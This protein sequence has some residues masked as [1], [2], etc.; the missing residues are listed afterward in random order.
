[1]T[2]RRKTREVWV[3]SVGIGGSHPV[4]I[5]SMTT[6]PTREVQATVEQ[7]LR[8]E[9]AGCELVR[10]TVQGMKEAESCEEIKTQLLQKNCSLPLIADIHFY[11]P[12]A[13]KVVDFVDKVRINPGNFLDKR[14]LFLKR[15]YDDSSYQEEL[16]RIKEG[17]LPFLDKCKRLGKPIRIGANHGSL[18]DRIMNRYGD[19][20]SGM[21]ESALEFAR[22]CREQEFHHLIFS[23]KASNPQVMIE[24][25]L[26]LV[27]HM[28]AL[29]WDYPLHLGVTEA[30]EGEDGRIKS[31]IGIGSLLLQGLGD[32][33][34]VSLTEDPWCEIEPAKLLVSYAKP[35]ATAPPLLQKAPEKKAMLIVEGEGYQP[36]TPAPDFLWIEKDQAQDGVQVDIPILS[37]TL[38]HPGVIPM[39]RLDSSTKE[40]REAGS[41]IWVSGEDRS[42][43]PY[44]ASLHPR[45]FLFSPSTCLYAEAKEFLYAL[46]QAGSSCEIVL[47]FSAK[48]LSSE[49][50]IMC[51]GIQYGSLLLEGLFSGICIRHTRASEA[52]RM[53][54]ALLQASRRRIVKTEFV[55]C[56]GCGRTLF[57]LQQVSRNIRERTSHL[58]GV[59]IAIMG[60][61]VNGPGEMADADFGYVG[62]RSGKIDLYVGK[63]CV[64]KNIDAELAVDR[65]IFLIKSQGKWIDST[66]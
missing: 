64:E 54:F 52:T 24:A 66:L 47:V 7:I 16:M 14:A 46:Q 11:P 53:G 17:F 58:P 15:E 20:P 33:L 35:V 23:M 25:Y 5:Q 61:I 51:L 40:Q 2:E 56:P 38:S 42:L 65:L 60:C 49:E 12:A 55:S 29:G 43:F 28:D 1:M 3:G 36:Q 37:A 30:G 6:S 9:Q 22:I 21:V 41:V 13:M 39:Y 63:E 59:R 19:T 31:A 62:S 10:V 57:D 26:L 32:T 45:F 44:A 50:A 48:D 27:K 4:R 18:S 34:R 8:L